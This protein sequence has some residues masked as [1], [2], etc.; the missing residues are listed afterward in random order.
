[1][2]VR[3]AKRVAKVLCLGMNQRVHRFG[4]QAMKAC[5]RGTSAEVETNKIKPEKEE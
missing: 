4:G 1:M 3:P 2:N 5:L